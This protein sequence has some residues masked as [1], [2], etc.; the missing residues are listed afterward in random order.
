M[1]DYSDDQPFGTPRRKPD[2]VLPYAIDSND[3]KFWTAPGAVAAEWAQYAIDTFEWLYREGAEAPRMMSLGVHLR[4][5]GR[6]G[7]IGAFE[8]VLAHI[9]AKP[10]VWSLPGAPSPSTL[11][12]PSRL[13]EP[14][15]LAQLDIC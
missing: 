8:R 1:D 12:P 2:R 15:P 6:P 3:M 7:R 10:G 13:R 4:I 11:Q 14:V 9:A 5:I